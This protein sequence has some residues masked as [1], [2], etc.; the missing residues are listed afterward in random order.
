[1]KTWQWLAL[2]G[3][4]AFFLLRKS[5][6]AT[7]ASAGALSITSGKDFFQLAQGDP[8][9]ASMLVGFSTKP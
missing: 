6:G 9:W 8:R 2:G 3:A 7:A 4:A 5:G 1:M